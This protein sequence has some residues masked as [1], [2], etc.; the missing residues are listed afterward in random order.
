MSRWV[1]EAGFVIITNIGKT[2]LLTINWLGKDRSL[3][4]RPVW[5]MGKCHGDN[6]GV[7]DRFCNYYERIRGGYAGQRTVRAVA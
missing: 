5:A 1:D 3:A 6:A 4:Y 2:K 7:A